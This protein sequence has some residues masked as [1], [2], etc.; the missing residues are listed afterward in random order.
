MTSRSGGAAGLA[1]E[2][3]LQQSSASGGRGG[4]MGGRRGSRGNFLQPIKCICI[5]CAMTPNTLPTLPCISGNL[6]RAARTLTQLYDEALRP[7]GLRSTQFTILQ[8][9]ALTGE[10][11]QGELGRLLAIDSTTLTRTLAI[12]ARQG[13]IVERPG[14]DRRERR[15]RLADAGKAEFQRAQPPWRKVQARIRRRLGE[16]A[17]KNLFQVTT[18]IANLFAVEG[19]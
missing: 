10:I 2:G 18:Q 13:W 1:D 17:W 8:A 19:E 11:R 7:L 5:Y 14:K 4:R 15:V 9:L 6:R 3:T 12:L 16:P